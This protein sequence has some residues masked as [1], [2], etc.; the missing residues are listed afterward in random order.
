[1][2]TYICSVYTYVLIGSPANAEASTMYDN[3]RREYNKRVKEVVEASWV[4]D[5]DDGGE[6]EDDDEADEAGGG[7]S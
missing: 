5:E 1:M 6:E 3:D 7:E 4:D 2:Y